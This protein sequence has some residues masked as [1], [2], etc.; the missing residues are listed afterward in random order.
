ML[1]GNLA[2]LQTAVGDQ[3]TSYRCFNTAKW[4][5]TAG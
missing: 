2:Q 1:D 5:N 4:V 3:G